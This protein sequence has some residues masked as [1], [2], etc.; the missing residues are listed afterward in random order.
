LT[1]DAA[2]Y[3]AY[4]AGLQFGTPPRRSNGLPIAVGESQQT[5]TARQNERARENAALT[6]LKASLSP[7]RTEAS[8]LWDHLSL[9]QRRNARL[10]GHFEA[11]IE[12]LQPTCFECEPDFV[13]KLMAPRLTGATIEALQD[14]SDVFGVAELVRICAYCDFVRD[15]LDVPW[16]LDM[17][18][19]VEGDK[20]YVCVAVK[21]SAVRFVPDNASLLWV[22]DAEYAQQRFKQPGHLKFG[23]CGAY[24]VGDSKFI[25]AGRTIPASKGE[26]VDAFGLHG[27]S[28]YESGDLCMVCT[29][30]A[31][32]RQHAVEL[33]VPLLYMTG[34]ADEETQETCWSPATNFQA[35]TVP[36]FTEG[37]RCELLMKTFQVHASSE[38]ELA[39][40]GIECHV[41]TGPTYVD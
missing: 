6:A 22:H 5:V 40:D 29:S 26:A 12:R 32:L 35:G 25:S 39:D 21:D 19:R 34:T 11:A 17:E 20:A 1:E 31:F 3:Q 4:C 18:V 15:A 33:K 9:D 8:P 13:G 10:R 38:K 28:L 7:E 30:P 36:G 14:S 41:L 37:L 23:M 24:A 16:P 27:Y 2:S